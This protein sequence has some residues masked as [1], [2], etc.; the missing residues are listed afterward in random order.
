MEKCLVAGKLPQHFSFKENANIVRQS[1]N[2]SWIEGY[3][4]K[5]GPYH[6]LRICTSEYETHDI[7]HACHNASPRVHYSTKKIVYKILQAR[8]FW[9]TLHKGAR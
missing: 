5:L 6:I 4:S 8:Y 1:K 3:I 2:Y 7:L 9:T